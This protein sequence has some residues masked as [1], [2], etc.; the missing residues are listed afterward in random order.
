[1]LWTATLLLLLL[2]LIVVDYFVFI[3]IILQ[4]LFFFCFVIHFFET[5]GPSSL[6]VALFLDHA[7]VSLIWFE[8]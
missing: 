6:L 2:L 5:L 1:M 3:S 4:S 7:V 8:K